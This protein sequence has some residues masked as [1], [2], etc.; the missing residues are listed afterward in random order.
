MRAEGIAKVNEDKGDRR[1][2]RGRLKNRSPD[3]IRTINFVLHIFYRLLIPPSFI[4]CVH[5]GVRV[6]TIGLVPPPS[7]IFSLF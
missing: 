5:A 1:T 2:I 6:L 7:P 3:I 4:Q